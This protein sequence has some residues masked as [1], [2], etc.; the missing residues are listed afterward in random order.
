MGLPK[1][2]VTKVNSQQD[3]CAGLFFRCRVNNFWNGASDSLRLSVEFKFLKRRS[4]KGCR[5]CQGFFD[6]VAEDHAIV[7]APAHPKDGAIYQMVFVPGPKDWETGYLD[8][9]S[10]RLLRHSPEKEDS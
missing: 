1:L 8:D 10:W 7:D 2:E 9:W 3:K 6:D 5:L 4:C